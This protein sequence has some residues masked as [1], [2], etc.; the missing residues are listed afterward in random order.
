M[1]ARTRFAEALPPDRLV[2]ELVGNLDDLPSRVDL[3]IVS[4]GAG[5]RRSIVEALVAGREISA[6]LL[7]KFLFQKLEDYPA[8]GSL[9]ASKGIPTF[10]NTPRRAWPAYRALAEE[11]AGDGVMSI[12]VELNRTNGLATNAIHFIDLAAFLTGAK[13]GFECDGGRLIPFEEVSRHVGAVE[14]GGVMTAFSSRGDFLSIRGRTESASPH[15]ISITS[16]SRRA[17]IHEIAQQAFI[18]DMASGFSPQM[19]EFPIVRQ[20]SL[21]GDLAAAILDRG[22]SPLPSYNESANLHL[23]CLRAFLTALGG[24]GDS[25]IVSVT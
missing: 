17:V 4:T 24:R 6:L 20:S 12:S 2:F 3:A 9:L 16:N 7:E 10:V 18:A 5:P 25:D 15:F 1:L 13:G 21:T 19:R 23:Q 22:S 14:F 11:F 8:V